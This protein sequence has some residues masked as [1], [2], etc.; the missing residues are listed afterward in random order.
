MLQSTRINLRF[1]AIGNPKEIY[2]YQPVFAKKITCEK[3]LPER[4]VNRILTKQTYIRHK[5]Y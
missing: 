3:N 4:K 5:T 1:R 2:V